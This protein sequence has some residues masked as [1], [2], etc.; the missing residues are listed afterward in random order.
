MLG[1]MRSRNRLALAPAWG[2]PALATAWSRHPYANMEVVVE[3]AQ[4]DR[5][6]KE[7]TLSR[8]MER[9]NSWLNKMMVKEMVLGVDRQHEEPGNEGHLWQDV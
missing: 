2:L 1:F 7:E 5:E 4:K 9:K 6:K 3:E 8:M